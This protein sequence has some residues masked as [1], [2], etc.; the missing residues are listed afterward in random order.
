ME[1]DGRASLL[2]RGATRRLSMFPSH[3]P[4]GFHHSLN[5]VMHFRVELLSKHFHES[6]EFLNFRFGDRLLTSV[7]NSITILYVTGQ[8]PSYGLIRGSLPTYVVQNLW[9]ADGGEKAL[10][11]IRMWVGKATAGLADKRVDALDCVAQQA[12]S[13]LLVDVFDVALQWETRS[14]DTDTEPG[15]GQ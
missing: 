2:S 14:Q 4:S 10:N 12:P 3:L 7:H 13:S 11:N 8:T 5:L 6:P 9:Q 1:K 15:T